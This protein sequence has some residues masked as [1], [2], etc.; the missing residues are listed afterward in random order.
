[1]RTLLSGNEAI[2]RGAYEFGVKVAAAYPG[3]PSTEILENVVQYREIHAQWS[4]NEK[5]AFEVASGANLAGVRAL[6]AMKHVGLNVAAD[7]LMTMSYV[8]VNGGLVVVSAD[9]P[10]MHSSQNE[11]DNRTYAKFAKIPMLEPSDSQEAKDFV[12]VAFELSRQFDTPVLLRVTTRICHGKSPVTWGERVVPELVAY[13]KDPKKTVMVPGHAR[14]RHVVVEERRRKLTVFSDTFEHNRIE[15]GDPSI[16]V[17]SSGIA[18][19]YAREI[20]PEASFLKLGMT[21]PMPE[22]LIRRFADQVETLYVVEELEPFLEEQIRAMGIEVVGK[23]KLP[24]TGEFAPE[25]VRAGFVSAPESPPEG[26]QTSDLPPRPPVLCPGCPHRGIFHVLRKLRLTVTGDIGCYTLSAL[27]PL[28]AMDTCVCMGA[29][30]GMATGIEKALGPE[31]DGRTVAV[32]GDSTF[33]HSGITGLVDMVYNRGHGTVIILDNRTTAMTGRQNHPG[34]GQTLREESTHELD[35]VSLAKAVGVGD[36]HVVDP[37]D[38]KETEVAVRAAIAHDG[39]SLIVA[40]RPCVLLVR[41]R[42]DAR[43]VDEELC[44]GCGRCLQLACPA[45]S[46]LD[47]VVQINP[48][49]CI[50][51]GVCAQVCPKDAI[52]ARTAES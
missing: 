27:P 25:V 3:T 34:T 32:I 29:G 15:M 40:R 37:R 9:D 28:N 21:Y 7:P 18:Y 31:Q 49:F 43:V 19:H 38:L 12:G 44:A 26:A 14:G 52:G 33:V 6:V 10:G 46:K 23:E 36:V 17:V 4:P 8:G 5:V 50:G 51:C 42:A 24:R 48:L 39:T 1:M 2:A 47:D 30:I 13:E 22:G 35:F 41:E 20:F 45:I 11:Q 16:G